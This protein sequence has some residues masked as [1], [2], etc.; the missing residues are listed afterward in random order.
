MRFGGG[1]GLVILILGAVMIIAAV[2]GTYKPALAAL[3]GSG[4]GA[5][6]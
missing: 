3:A 2:R 6:R 4:T 5:K 1:V